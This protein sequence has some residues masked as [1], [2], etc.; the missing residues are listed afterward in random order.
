MNRFN[1]K[2]FKRFWKLVKPYWVSNEK[3]GAIAILSL[4]LILTLAYTFISVSIT[5]FQG[6]L[7]SALTKFDRER[8]LKTIWMFLGVLAIFAPLASISAYLQEKLSNYWRRWLTFDFLG[9]YFGDRAF[10]E[11]GNLNTELDNPSIFY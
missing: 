9:R 5:R 10:Y 11:L 6:D 3:W 2:A 8:F 4:L 7:I 1:L